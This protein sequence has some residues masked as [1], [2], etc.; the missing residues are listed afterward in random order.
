MFSF[1]ENKDS[2]KIEISGEAKELLEEVASRLELNKVW[3]I[4]PIALQKLYEIIDANSR[5]KENLRDVWIGSRDE[6]R[7]M[8]L[9]DVEELRII[10]KKIEMEWKGENK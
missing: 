4:V 1:E 5:S 7:G 6:T 9:F 8:K 2:L 3:P 10:G